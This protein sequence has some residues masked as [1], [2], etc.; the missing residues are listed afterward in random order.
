MLQNVETKWFRNECFEE[1]FPFFS[2]NKVEFF[3]T[4]EGKY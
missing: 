4:T 2:L 3:S 1:M